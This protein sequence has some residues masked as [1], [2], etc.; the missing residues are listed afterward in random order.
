MAVSLS[1]Y[2]TGRRGAG[3]PGSAPASPERTV[4]P[5]VR[6]PS[7]RVANA[8]ADSIERALVGGAAHCGT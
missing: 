5:K 8:H 1:A 7:A 6:A 4:R 3:P 2:L